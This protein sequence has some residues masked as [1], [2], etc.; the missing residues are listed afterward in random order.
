VAD[1]DYDQL[2]QAIVN[3]Q[4]RANRNQ[5][6]DTSGQS[7]AGENSF[8]SSL[9]SRFDPL[10][11]GLAGAAAGMGEMEIAVAGVVSNL[12]DHAGALLLGD[13]ALRSHSDILT[14]NITALTGNIPLVEALGGVAAN[15]TTYLLNTY[16]SYKTL[17]ESGMSLGGDLF[18]LRMTAANA[19][20]NLDEF[21]DLVTQNTSQL[22]ALGVGVSGGTKAFANMSR[23]FF[24][25]GA[26][27]ELFAL[28]ISAKEQ[29]E[30]LLEQMTI[31]RRRNRG[32]G[33]SQEELI[34]STQKYVSE[35]D[36][37][38]K[39]TGKS[40]KEL[41][42]QNAE[43]MRDG[44]TQARLRLLERQGVEGAAQTYQ[45]MQTQIQSLGPGFQD[46][47]Q[48]YIQMGVPLTDATKQLAAS[49][50]EAARLLSEAANAMKAGNEEAAME[51]TRQAEA[52]ALAQMNSNQGLQMA[53]MGQLGGVAE[54][55]ANTL[56]AN[57]D[58]LDQVNGM[59]EATGQATANLQSFATAL[60]N[61]RDQ[62]ATERSEQLN[63]EVVGAMA[64]AE[65][66]LVDSAASATTAILEESRTAIEGVA[67]SARDALAD[68]SREGTDD[69]AN[70]MASMAPAVEGV[71]QRV[72]EL[73]SIL[74]NNNELSVQQ[75]E[76]I[77]RT[78]D[79]LRAAQDA[80]NSTVAG[81]QERADAEQ[82]MQS[83]MDASQQ[84]TATDTSD[85]S[86][87]TRAA[88]TLSEIWQGI[89][90]FFGG[91]DEEEPEMR[92]GTLGA[93]GTLFKDFGKETSALLHGQE[94]VI[95]RNSPQ[96]D[97]L[98]AFPGGIGEAMA[99]MQD[100]M[101]GI[102]SQMSA[103]L[104]QLR[105]STPQPATSRPR[106]QSSAPTMPT[107]TANQTGG[108]QELANMLNEKLDIMNQAMLQLV[109]INSRTADYGKRQVRELRNASGSV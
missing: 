108:N 40:R 86:I 63:N 14:K 50:P 77:Q 60:A 26:S 54:V 9:V 16:D 22:T 107:V 90:S 80:I 6:R 47:L 24:D 45:S 44:A 43:R 106:S 12:K 92:G 38:A 42:D 101:P 39:L 55:A 97:L 61:I 59:R 83:L 66:T 27:R 30:L 109:E 94:A 15:A 65:Q 13:T 91:G 93:F 8:W 85:D 2:A 69:V 88:D 35:L 102:A 11:V 10:N 87:T 105:S 48:D 56:Q 17:S 1:I 21:S 20:L 49:S 73:E 29:N 28:G 34:R 3:A 41:Q 71:N 51:L 81:S 68:V 96:G 37:I 36:T 64:S 18:D 99:S 76:I 104:G 19:R 100:A 58:L 72:G 98:S 78:I 75:R 32:E 7:G 46:L 79:N 70:T 33:L 74:Q 67:G 23:Q 53:A 31:N 62:I 52:A 57:Q 103:S 4:N 84:L 25:S 89:K 95:P 82:A 5:P